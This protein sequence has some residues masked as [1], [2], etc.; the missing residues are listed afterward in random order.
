MVPYRFCKLV[1]WKSVRVTLVPKVMDRFVLRFALQLRSS[2]KELS[3]E[4][5]E[6]RKKQGRKSKS[7]KTSSCKKII[8]ML[9][10]T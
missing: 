3:G 2:C 7:E 5:Y 1:A 4:G 8:D 10:M 9:N 6:I